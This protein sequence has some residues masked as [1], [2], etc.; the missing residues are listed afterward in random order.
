MLVSHSMED[1]ANYAERLIVMNQG[2]VLYDDTPREVFRHYKELEPVGLAAP[3]ITYIMH[4][5]HE[6]GL[7][8]DTDATT[9]E[10]AK[11][12]ILNALGKKA[13][14]RSKI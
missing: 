12:S 1:M 10:E 3:Q 8:V 5:L 7:N 13:P 11:A 9:V 14:G 6:R 2:Q 4:A